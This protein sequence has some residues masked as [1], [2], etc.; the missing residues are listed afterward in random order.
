MSH[1]RVTVV[2]VGDDGIESAPE[3]ATVAEGDF[4]LIPYTPCYLDS[5]QHYGTK[6]TTVLTVKNHRMRRDP[7]PSVRNLRA[8]ALPDPEV[9]N[10]G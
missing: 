1:L 3:T 2:E 4:I 6:G 8:S 7:D 9:T 10:R 5:A